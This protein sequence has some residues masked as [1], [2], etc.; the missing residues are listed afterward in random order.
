[1]RDRRT[2]NE[3]ASDKVKQAF[4][5]KFKYNSDT[6]EITRRVKGKERQYERL[7]KKGY[8]EAIY[9]VIDKVEYRATYHRLCWFLHYKKVV[10][11]SMQIDHKNNIK[12]HNWIDNL[13]IC[14]NADNKKKTSM[15]SN[16]TTGYKGVAYSKDIN[17]QGKVYHYYIA[18]I[19]MKPK[20]IKIGRFK[21]DKIAAVFYDAAARHYYKQWASCNYQEEYVPICDVEELRKL[22]KNKEFINQLK[23]KLYGT[24]KMDVN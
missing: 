21:E 18:G 3:S 13:Q 4:L 15:Y 9:L 24:T 20:Y 1:M 10:P 12:V 2:F 5:E 17:Q 11:D 22:K 7:S 16:N 23:Q 19:S 14:K 6:G 8:V